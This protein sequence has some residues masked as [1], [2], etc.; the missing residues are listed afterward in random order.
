MWK[1]PQGVQA[2]QLADALSFAMTDL[3][4]AA[5]RTADKPESGEPL[6]QRKKSE[7][8]QLVLLEQHSKKAASLHS[9]QEKSG[10]KPGKP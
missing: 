4:L 7:D 8:S 2:A 1:H 5:L 3:D 10:R 6:Y 9:G